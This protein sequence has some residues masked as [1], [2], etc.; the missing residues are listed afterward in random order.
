MYGKGIDIDKRKIVLDKDIVHDI[1]VETYKL[2]KSLFLNRRKTIYNNLSNHL[3][4]KELA[5]SILSTLNIEE[6]KRPEEI[7]SEMYLKMLQLI[8]NYWRFS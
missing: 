1:A 6:N 3:K 5:K 2:A 8:K 4:N 7:A